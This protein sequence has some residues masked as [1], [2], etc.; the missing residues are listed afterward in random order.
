MKITIEKLPLSEDNREQLLVSFDDRSRLYRSTPGVVG[1]DAAAGLADMVADAVRD[2]FYPDSATG[3]RILRF[4][5][6]SSM[7]ETAGR[8]SETPG[9]RYDE[10]LKRWILPERLATHAEEICKHR[11]AA[12]TP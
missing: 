3:F 1:A 11:K 7:W 10:E 8:A 2:I 9:A 5:D 4:A 6:G 12:P